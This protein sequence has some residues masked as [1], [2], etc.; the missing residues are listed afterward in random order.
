MDKN[1]CYTFDHAMKLAIKREK[2]SLQLY[3]D[4]AGKVKDATAKNFL[5]ELALAE[6]E[7]QHLLERAL[8]EGKTETLGPREVQTMQ[9]S[10]YLI[11]IELTSELSLQDAMI[12]AMKDEKKS[13]EFYRNLAGMCAGNPMQDLFSRLEKE[14]LKHLEKLETDYEKTFMQW[15]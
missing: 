4:W 11:D 1:V 15:M 12:H 7:H 6:L 8:Y 9:L 3:N 2:A 5:K 13:A 10:D 14:E